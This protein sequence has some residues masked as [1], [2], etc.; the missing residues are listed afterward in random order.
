M[1]FS[2]AVAEV[3]SITGRPDKAADIASQ[4]NRAL[5]FF[6]L[7]AE[8]TQDLVETS[9]AIDST[10]YGNTISLVSLTRFRKFKYLRPLAQRYYLRSIDPTQIFIPGQQIQRDR[11]YVGGASLTYL[12]S[13]L[14]TSLEV[15]YFTY[16]PILTSTTGSDAHWML[17]L[18]P[19]ALIE[20]AA[21]K[22]F[23]L[24]GDDT[25]YK[26]Y[27][28]SA[29]ELFLTGRKDFQDQTSQEAF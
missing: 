18:M 17:D 10:L 27:E 9:L 15:G 28:G 22:I 25:S 1:I 3:I 11:Y 23:Q 24:I 21:A 8:F 5:S 6:T 26:F 14:D 16:A 13:Q 7:K 2:E 4:L 12:L 20:K 19:Y 29:M